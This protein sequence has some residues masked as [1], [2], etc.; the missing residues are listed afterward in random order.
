MQ[1]RVGHVPRRWKV[2]ADAAAAKLTAT[3]ADFKLKE[4]MIGFLTRA[5]SCSGSN[6]LMKK[7]PD[8]YSSQALYKHSSQPGTTGSQLPAELQG[9]T[10]VP[11]GPPSTTMISSNARPSGVP[12]H[13]GNRHGGLL[14]RTSFEQSNARLGLQQR[15]QES[16]HRVDCEV[17]DLPDW[18]NEPRSK[19]HRM[20]GKMIAKARKTPCGGG[21]A[22]H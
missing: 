8:A 1:P 7:R 17:D 14:H 18:E 20:L 22:C 2:W 13:V 19:D 16:R 3:A 21:E 11:L 12:R 5:M 15:V 10:R 9:T 6:T 4:T